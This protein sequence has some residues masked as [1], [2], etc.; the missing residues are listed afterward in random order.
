MEEFS[1]DQ[2]YISVLVYLFFLFNILVPIII[3]FSG[4]QL[5][6]VMLVQHYLKTTFLVY[7]VLLKRITNMMH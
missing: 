3:L 4:H 2:G 5:V 1:S 7:K 6:I